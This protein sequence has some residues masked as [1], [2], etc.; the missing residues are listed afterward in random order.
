MNTDEGVKLLKEGK[1]IAFPT[2]TSYG[3]AC[4]PFNEKAIQE[5]H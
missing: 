4:D 3:L 1:I 2:E 5:L